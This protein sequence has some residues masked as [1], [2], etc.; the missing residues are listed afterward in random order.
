MKTIRRFSCSNIHSTTYLHGGK[1]INLQI[2]GVYNQANSCNG[3]QISGGLNI[4][5][6]TTNGLQISS[7]YNRTSKLQGIQI[8]LINYADTIEHGFPIGLINIIK[9]G[10]QTLEF[11]TDE[12]FYFN[13][14]YKTGGKTLYSFLKVGIGKY[15]NT[16]YGIGIT[17]NLRHRFS[18]NLDL[19]GSA[20]FNTNSNYDLFAGDLYRAQL[21]LNFKISE[22]T[23]LTTGPSYNFCSPYKEQDTVTNPSLSNK[24]SIYFGNYHL[25][26]AINTRKS[27]FW[28]GWQMGLR[29]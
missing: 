6:G 27:Q 28:F 14:T 1:Q 15:I 12:S 21:G 3:L 20:L 7:L 23:T 24:S 13:A 2:S 16:A 19:S 4:V 11:S 5:K 10:Y 18:V 29:F 26:K 9:N 22:H 17:S 8:G 25:D